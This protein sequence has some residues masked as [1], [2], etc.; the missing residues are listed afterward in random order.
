MAVPDESRNEEVKAY[1]QLCEGETQ[2]TFTPQD[3]IDYCKTKIAAFKIPRYI[4]YRKEFELT[5]V[6]KVIKGKL[7]SSK[8]DL[9]AGCYDREANQ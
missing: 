2:E 5:S 9:T 1:I 3:I 6:G 4:E 7:I 8:Q